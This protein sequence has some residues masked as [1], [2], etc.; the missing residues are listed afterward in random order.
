M[1]KKKLAIVRTSKSFGISLGK[2]VLR[3]FTF[4]ESELTSFFGPIK[5]KVARIFDE[6]K[7]LILTSLMSVITVLL[8]SLELHKERESKLIF[9]AR[10]SVFSQKIVV[11]C[12]VSFPEL[13]RVGK[14]RNIAKSS[15]PRKFYAYEIVPSLEGTLT[16][17]RVTAR[18]KTGILELV[19]VFASKSKGSFV[20]FNVSAIF[21][22]KISTPELSVVVSTLFAGKIGAITRVNAR[23]IF[24]RK[25]ASSE[26]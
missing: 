2:T 3:K 4:Y 10:K 1:D 21:V 11:T 24:S 25:F 5:S 17:F 12:L 16:G 7:I 20:S 14:S 19:I 26:K 22:E 18:T 6:T 23:P 8:V 13:V 9:L 15:S